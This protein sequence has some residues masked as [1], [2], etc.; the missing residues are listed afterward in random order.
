MYLDFTHGVPFYTQSS[1]G[2]S[3]GG[4][5]RF[6]ASRCRRLPRFPGKSAGG[7]IWGF[8]RRA[9]YPPCPPELSVSS[10]GFDFHSGLRNYSVSAAVP[11]VG[12]VQASFPTSPRN[13]CLFTG[14]LWTGL[15]VVGRRG[16]FTGHG[17]VPFSPGG[18]TWHP[19]APVPVTAWP[20]REGG[21]GASPALQTGAVL[22]AADRPKCRLPESSCLAPSTRLLLPDLP[23]EPPWLR[24]PAVRR[25]VRAGSSVRA[26]TRTGRL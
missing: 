9:N 5:G 16:T 10:T 4:L 21:R 23:L 25:E 7:P 3:R 20:A 24:T 15:T 22:G 18:D 17:S 11:E 8:D 2:P 26:R 19:R 1:H 13:P 6:L 14:G 12:A